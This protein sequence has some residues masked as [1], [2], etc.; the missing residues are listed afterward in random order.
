MNNFSK[1]NKDKF[2]VAW[3]E[4]VYYSYNKDS[5]IN[6]FSKAVEETSVDDLHNWRIIKNDEILRKEFKVKL[7][8]EPVI[9]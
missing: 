2:F 9:R 6:E 5:V 4:S 3:K 8:I 1:I 7:S